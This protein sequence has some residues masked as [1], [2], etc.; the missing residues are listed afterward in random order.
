MNEC[1]EHNMETQEQTDQQK[2]TTEEEED[3]VETGSHSGEGEGP[4]R[5]NNNTSLVSLI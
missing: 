4:I 1:Y 5:Q 3:R 2:Q